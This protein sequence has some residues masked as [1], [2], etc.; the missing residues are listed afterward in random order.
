MR[1]GGCRTRAATQPQMSSVTLPRSRYSKPD[2]FRHARDARWASAPPG[3]HGARMVRN[4]PW[5]HAWVGCAETPHEEHA[6]IQ[7][8]EQR[9]A[10]HEKVF[11]VGSR[12]SDAVRGVRDVQTKR[13]ERIPDVKQKSG[14]VRSVYQ[15]SSSTKRC[16]PL[17]GL[18]ERSY[19]DTR[20]EGRP[21]AD[22]R[23]T[24]DGP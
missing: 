13:E 24:A 10:G 23:P 12:P 22:Q 8:N 21:R 9:H 17:D 14:A 1:A 7:A 15:P 16:R 4:S 3:A 11:H 5:P 18:V 6:Q 20:W 19:R 2:S